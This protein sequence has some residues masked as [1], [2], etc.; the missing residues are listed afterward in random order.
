MYIWYEYNVYTH[1]VM[2]ITLHG[3]N[4]LSANSNKINTKYA[5][6]LIGC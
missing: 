2:H 1:T 3:D 4:L 6:R 5:L